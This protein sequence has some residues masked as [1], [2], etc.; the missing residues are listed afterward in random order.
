M[1]ST[2]YRIYRTSQDDPFG[3]PRGWLAHHGQ[4]PMWVSSNELTDNDLYPHD[5]AHSLCDDWN[6]FWASKGWNSTAILEEVD[7]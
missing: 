7:Q 5:E 3:S 6:D 1:T 4:M 2:M